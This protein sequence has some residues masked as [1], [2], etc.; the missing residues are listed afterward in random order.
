M[1]ADVV[2][3]MDE[4]LDQ[5][6]AFPKP[7]SPPAREARHVPITAENDLESGTEAHG[8]RCDRWGHPCPGCV[9]SP[10]EPEQNAALFGEVTNKR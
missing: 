2:L 4:Y 8:C 10:H 3:T 9:N 6:C 1:K 7:V 5:C